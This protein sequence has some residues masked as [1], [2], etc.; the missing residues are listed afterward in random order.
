MENGAGSGRR[1]LLTDPR[2][3]CLVA[4]IRVEVVERKEVTQL[5]VCFEGRQGLLVD[6]IRQRGVKHASEVGPGQLE[7]RNDAA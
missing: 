6:G 2:A 3:R 7:S 4:W 1:R 5:Q